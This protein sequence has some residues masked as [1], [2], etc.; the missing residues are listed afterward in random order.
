L[1]ALRRGD[2]DASIDARVVNLDGALAGA[3]QRI[4]DLFDLASAEDW[5]DLDRL[6]LRNDRYRNAR[7]GSAVI[8]EIRCGRCGYRVAL[9]QKDGH[10]GLHRLYLNR[11]L[12]PRRYAVLDSRPDIQRPN[13]LP[14][15]ICAACGTLIGTPMRH[16]DGRLAFRLVPG[17]FSKRPGHQLARWAPNPAQPEDLGRQ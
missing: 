3:A 4:C 13:D 10:G 17:S 6:K 14:P 8:L 5:P 12:A 9:Y 1:E 15:V 11:I 2:F 16:A 7:G